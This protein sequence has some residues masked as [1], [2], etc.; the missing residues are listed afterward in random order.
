MRKLSVLLAL[1]TIFVGSAYADAFLFGYTSNTEITQLVL[2]Q[3]PIDFAY[4]GWYD[5]TGS[6]SADNWNYATG[7]SVQTIYRDFFVFNIPSSELPYTEAYLYLYN[8]SSGF[9]NSSGTSLTY[10]V[11]DVTTGLAALEA[12]Q[13][14]AVST[15]NDLGWGV[16]YGSVVATA[17]DNGQY[18]RVDLNGNALADINAARGGAIAFGGKADALESAVPEPATFSLFGGAL[19]A[20]GFFARRRL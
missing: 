14:S 13:T 12:T 6:H 3:T 15:F 11:H 9:F 20:L 17:A 5:Q 2:G 1:V 7:T 16:F 18:V 19:L 10:A 4:R 8:P